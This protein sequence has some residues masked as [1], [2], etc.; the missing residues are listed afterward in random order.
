MVLFV[1]FLEYKGRQR[2]MCL[3]SKSLCFLIAILYLIFLSRKTLIQIHFAQDHM[4]IDANSAQLPDILQ[5]SY[6]KLVQ[7]E[8]DFFHH[9]H[10]NYSAEILLECANICR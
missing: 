4:T 8:K 7:V 3:F 2:E 5:E 1:D 9:G 10:K 6:N